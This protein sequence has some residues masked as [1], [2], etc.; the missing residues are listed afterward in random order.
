MFRH[1][2]MFKWNDDTTDETKAAVKAGLDT[3]ID[4][5]CVQGYAHGPDA[6]VSDGNWDYV[7]VGDFASV[8]DYKIYAVEAGHVALI[9]NHIKPSISAR[10]AVQYEC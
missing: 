1:T 9:N 3:M 8:D 2:V 10:A 6:G 5:D 7:A 4:L